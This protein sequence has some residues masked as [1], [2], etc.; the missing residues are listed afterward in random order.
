MKFSLSLSLDRSHFDEKAEAAA[1][2]G[3]GIDIAKKS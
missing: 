3:I 1:N 2:I